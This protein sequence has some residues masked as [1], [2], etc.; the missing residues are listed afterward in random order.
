MVLQQQKINS[1][2]IKILIQELISEHIELFLESLNVRVKK[3]GKKYVG[4]CPVHGGDNPMAFVIYPNG[5]NIKC[6]WNCFTHQCHK[7]YGY[8]I[9]SLTKTLLNVSEQEAIVYI[10]NFLK[11]DINDLKTSKQV[12]DRLKYISNNQKLQKK[13]IVEVGKSFKESKMI[14]EA[15]SDYFIKRGYNKDILIKYNIG[16]FKNGDYSNRVIV[17][18]YDTTGNTMIGFSGRTI[19]PKCNKCNKFHSEHNSCPVTAQELYHSCK[20]IVPSNFSIHNY[21]YNYWFAKDIINRDKYAIL[22]EGPGDVWRLEENNEY[23]SLGLFGVELTDEQLIILEKS[24]IHNLFLALDN[25][26]AGRKSVEI[27]K[28]QCRRLFNVHVLLYNSKD[29]GEISSKDIQEIKSQI[30]LKI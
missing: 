8:D 5:Y 3:S 9:I 15:P 25:D 28:K 17:P 21:L 10:C 6:N 2:F 20:W 16:P 30:K 19:E 22:V 1:K 4:C 26:E 13:T 27:I 24:G 7:K 12:E 14:I 11:I 23:H 18:V 29:I